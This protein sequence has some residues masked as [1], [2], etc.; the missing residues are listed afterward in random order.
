[1][2][3]N[4]VIAITA[5]DTGVGKT[6][7]TRGLLRALI[8]RGKKP[9]PLKWVET[10]CSDDTRS[11]RDALAEAAKVESQLSDVGPIRLAIPAAPTVAARHE[12]RVLVLTDYNDVLETAKYHGEMVIVE[13]AGGVLVPMTEDRNFADLC[14]VLQVQCAVIVARTTL[15]TINHTAL[16]IEA[17]QHRKIRILAVVL[18]ESTQ[19]TDDSG[20][21][22]ELKRLYPHLVL[23]PLP[24][25]PSS[26]DDQLASAVTD[27][28]L[29]AR[30]MSLGAE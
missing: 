27:C 9:F 6:T 12:G 11:D 10:G 2:K 4:L 29:T 30:V 22:D 20:S 17:L 5:T 13:G 26:T 3:T 28:G 23:G 1:M 21:C 8:D 16:T 25:L 19:T 24:W 14:V 18:N 7:V 15:G